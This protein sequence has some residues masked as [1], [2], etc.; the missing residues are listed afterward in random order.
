MNK[1]LIRLTESDLHRIVKESVDKILRESWSDDLCK[2]MKGKPGTVG[3]PYPKQDPKFA[4]PSWDELT[5]EE[6]EFINNGVNGMGRHARRCVVRD[7]RL[8]G[9]PLKDYLNKR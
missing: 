5:P 2:S 1:K 6:L 7:A 9:M 4:L 8:S 3:N